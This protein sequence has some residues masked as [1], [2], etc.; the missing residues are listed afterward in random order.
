MN[1]YDLGVIGSG[2]GGLICAA[3]FALEGKKVCVLEKNKQIGG[4]LQSYSRNRVIFDSGVHYVGGL[5][6]GQ[7]LY[8]IFDYLGIMDK[9]K[10]QRLDDDVFD[11]ISFCDDPV[12]YKFA[13]GYENFIRTLSEQFPSEEPAIRK[14][15]DDIRQICRKFPLYNLHS[16]DYIETLSALE[17]DT[18]AYIESITS[19][20]KLQRVLAGN[21]FLYAGEG[22]KTPLYVH[23]LISNHYIESSYRFINGSSQVARELSKQITSRQ[24]R[25]LKH[26]KVIRLVEHEEKISFAE[27][28]DGRKFYAPLFISNVHP[29]NTLDMIEGKTLKAAYKKRIKGLENTISFFAVNVVL[30]KNSFPYLNY[31]I[32]YWNNKVPWIDLSQAETL[33][34]IGYVMYFSKSQKNDYYSDGVT[35]LSYMDFREVEKWK[36]THNTVGEESDRGDDYHVF[37]ETKARDLFELVEK[38]FPGFS[39]L[40]QS[41]YCMTPLTGRDYSGN[42]DGT[43]Y[44]FA[45]DFRDPLKTFISPRTKISNLLLTGQGINL[46]GVLGVSISAL[47]TCSIVFG[48][49]YLIS[50]IKDA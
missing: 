31:N 44:G 12:R 10:I 7:N 34:R 50:K 27:L 9:L 4:M 35:I 19:D 3:I 24:G 8:R 38:R 11:E 2:L 28:E 20:R 46:H 42:D 32:N 5:D 23:A 40:I 36:N 26:C 48:M 18:K 13:Q 33:S 22:N 47:N 49:P 41:Y 29:K 39:S 17:Q 1:H 45:K 6:K 43:L 15:C 14:Y 16:G 30:K 25:I 21:N 37:K